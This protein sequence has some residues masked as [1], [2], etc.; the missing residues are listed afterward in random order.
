M[1]L[2]TL[3]L[4]RAAFKII[5]VSLMLLKCLGREGTVAAKPS[6]IPI[7]PHWGTRIPAPWLFPGPWRWLAS[8]GLQART[9]P[10]CK[11]MSPSLCP[12]PQEKPLAMLLAHLVLLFGR[13]V[14]CSC[15][16]TCGGSKR[17]AQL[18]SPLLAPQGCHP[19]PWGQH[20]EG[21][22]LPGMLPKPQVTPGKLQLQISAKMQGDPRGEPPPTPQGQ[23]S[24]R[25]SPT[26]LAAAG[27][28]RG[29]RFFFFWHNFLS[30]LNV[31]ALLSSPP[32]TWT[33]VPSRLGKEDTG[34]QLG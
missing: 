20:A 5:F 30:E 32:R 14:A 29:S 12:C 21:D 34:D 28:H 33:R 22:S 7:D 27:W 24:I 26:L 13:W 16:R 3:Q 11:D 1:E 17:V 6:P 25:G 10:P 4:G 2:G 15:V 23:T 9:V 31:G 19:L 18:L 8:P